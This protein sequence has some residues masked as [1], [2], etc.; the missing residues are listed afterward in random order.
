ML[1][2]Q[3]WM[4][5]PMIDV[6]SWTLARNTVIESVAPAPFAAAAAMFSCCSMIAAPTA[7]KLMTSAM[8]CRCFDWRSSSNASVALTP[9]S[10]FDRE[11]S[12]RRLRPLPRDDGRHEH[13]ADHHQTCR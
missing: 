9:F 11:R 3:T 4:T 2:S 1:V 6:H 12:G 10:R 13:G 8:I 5:K 7:A